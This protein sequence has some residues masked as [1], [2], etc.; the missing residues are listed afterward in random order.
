MRGAR[1][2][3]DERGQLARAPAGSPLPRARCRRRASARRPRRRGTRRARARRPSRRARSRRR[4]RR[5]ARACARPTTS[6]GTSSSAIVAAQ[7]ACAAHVDAEQVQRGAGEDAGERGDGEQPLGH[8][9]IVAACSPLHIGV[10]PDPPRGGNR[11][12]PSSETRTCPHGRASGGKAMSSSQR[13]RHA[14]K[15]QPRSR[16][17]RVERSS[18]DASRPKRPRLRL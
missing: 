14:R 17:S 13:R 15:R 3:L 2:A 1:R 4:R 9:R 11:R 5:A 18:D 6:S 7:R 16:R 12:V 8:P 10:G